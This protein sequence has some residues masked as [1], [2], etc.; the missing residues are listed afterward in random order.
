MVICVNFFQTELMGEIYSKGLFRAIG[1]VLLMKFSWK[2]I[3]TNN[4]KWS[5]FVK[6]TAV[7]VVCVNTI[8]Q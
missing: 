7:F 6:K 4:G 5:L 8:G 1:K 3:K 2:L